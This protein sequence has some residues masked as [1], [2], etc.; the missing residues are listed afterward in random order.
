M[1]P[2]VAVRGATFLGVSPGRRYHRMTLQATRW[3]AHPA[4]AVPV[5]D[6]PENDRAGTEGARAPLPGCEDTE[7]TKPAGDWFENHGPQPPRIRDGETTPV[8]GRL[9]VRDPSAEVPTTG[10]ISERS[11]PPHPNSPSGRQRRQVPATPR[12]PTRRGAAGEPRREGR[13]A[14][15]PSEGPACRGPEGANAK[16]PPRR[17]EPQAEPNGALP[18]GPLDRDHAEDTLQSARPHCQCGGAARPTPSAWPHS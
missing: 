11:P 15:E 3:Q 16:T 13:P 17:P 4:H 7:A 12:P 8:G 10:A 2:A 9:P 1:S 5:N 14:V 6:P 18:H